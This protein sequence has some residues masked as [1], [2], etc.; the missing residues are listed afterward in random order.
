[1]NKIFNSQTYIFLCSF[2]MLNLTNAISF[3]QDSAASSGSS[4]QTT[5]TTTQHATTV[6]VWIW[7]VGGVILLSIIIALLSRNKGGEVAHT[8]KVTYTKTTSR[9]TNS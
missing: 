4:T 1:M 7:I 3:A 8:D 6:P 5:T 9:D 2:I